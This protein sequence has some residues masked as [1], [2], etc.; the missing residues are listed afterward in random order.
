MDSFD[1]VSLPGS[2]AL[3]S[4]NPNYRGTPRLDYSSEKLGLDCLLSQ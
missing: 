1:F 3:S 4:I 2:T